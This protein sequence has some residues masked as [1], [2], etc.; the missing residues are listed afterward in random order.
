MNKNFFLL[1]TLAFCNL[2]GTYKSKEEIIFDVFKNECDFITSEIVKLDLDNGRYRDMTIIIEET[3][4]LLHAETQQKVSQYSSQIVKNKKK[5]D[6]LKKELKKKTKKFILDNESCLTT[7]EIEN[8]KQTYY[9]TQN[10]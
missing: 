1:L 9:I 8:L 2:N 7:S 3:P 6:K 10:L 5:I 4:F